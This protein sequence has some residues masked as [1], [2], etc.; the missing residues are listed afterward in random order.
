MTPEQ[1][2]YWLQGKFEGRDLKVAPLSARE[3]EEMSKHLDLV[4]THA[5]KGGLKDRVTISRKVF[6]ELTGSRPDMHSTLLC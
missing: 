4:F 3:Q 6:K 2:C 1:F 5:P